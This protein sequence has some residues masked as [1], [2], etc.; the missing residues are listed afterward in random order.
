VRKIA[1]VPTLLT[2][3]NG[4]CGFAAIASASK[5]GRI[6]VGTGVDP[7]FAASGWLIVAAMVFDMLDGYVARLSR[8]TGKFGG[9]R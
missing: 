5:I 2:L 6:D 1:V 8:S 7:Y 4:V 3:G 9:G